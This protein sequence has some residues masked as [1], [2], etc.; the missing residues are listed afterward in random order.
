MEQVV[1]SWISA[2]NIDKLLLLI[3]DRRRYARDV[4]TERVCGGPIRRNL[5]D[6]EGYVRIPRNFLFN[7][8][9]FCTFYIFHIYSVWICVVSYVFLMG[10]VAR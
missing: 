7:T 2:V 5:E 4:K 3:I 1:Y 6:A 10:L 8:I 9:P